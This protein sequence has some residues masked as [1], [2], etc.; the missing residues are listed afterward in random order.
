[1][2]LNHSNKK[3]KQQLFEEG[4]LFIKVFFSSLMYK[5]LLEVKV[6]VAKDF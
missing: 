4:L 2:R 1:M 5:I 3:S 6:I